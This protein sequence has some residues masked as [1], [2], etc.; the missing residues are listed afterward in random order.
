ME[1][2]FKCARKWCNHANG[3]LNLC[4]YC[5]LR[6]ENMST[7]SEIIIPPEQAY[8][9]R[10]LADIHNQAIR[11]EFADWLEEIQHTGGYD[12]GPQPDESNRIEVLRVPG[13]TYFLMEIEQGGRKVYRHHFCLWYTTPDNR[14][15]SLI[16]PVPMRPHCMICKKPIAEHILTLPNENRLCCN[17]SDCWRKFS[18]NDPK[19]IFERYEQGKP[20][21]HDP[22]EIRGDDTDKSAID[23]A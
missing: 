17:N 1:K 9:E 8:A 21:T 14:K 12:L 10:I 3:S 19:R 11:F 15:C 18:G 23:S 2:P 5:F 13:E 6:K 22:R 4:Y 20:T 16:G 7:E